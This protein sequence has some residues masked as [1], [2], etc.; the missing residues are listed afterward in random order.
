M[1]KIENLTAAHIAPIA[2]AFAKLGWNK[3]ASQYERYLD[4]QNRGLRAVLVAVVDGCF[5]GYLTIVWDSHCAFLREN[6]IPEIVDFNVLPAYRRRGIGTRLM[7]AAE[8]RIGKKSPLA[9][10][11]VGLTA[12][13]GPA[14]I[15]YIRR[16]Y[17]PTGQG[18]VQDGIPVQYGETITL[19]DDQAI[20]FVKNL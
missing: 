12:D 3:P 4:E 6:Q 7:D 18:L 14:H 5:G 8:L 1:V 13:Y 10:I 11:G 9:G 2:A 16:G 20:Y 15:L 17:L 19:N